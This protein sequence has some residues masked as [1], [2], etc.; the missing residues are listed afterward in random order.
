MSRCSHINIVSVHPSV[1][2]GGASIGQCQNE[3]IPGLVV[4]AKHADKEAL[5]ILVKQLLKRIKELEQ[6]KRESE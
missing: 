2:I 1:K 6:S 4:C 5:V 3:C